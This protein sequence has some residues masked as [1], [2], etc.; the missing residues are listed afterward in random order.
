MPITGSGQIALIA[1][2]EAEFAQDGDTDISL[3]T[4]R[5]DAGLSGE[6]QMSDFYSQSDA[7][8]PSVSTSTSSSLTTS[9]MQANGNVSS[10]GGGTISSRGFYFGTSSNYASNTKY[11]VS[12]TTGGF[13]RNMTG[14]SSGTTYYS[15]AFAINSIGEVRGG[16]SGSSTSVL[17][18]MTTSSISVSAWS[19][20]GYFGGNLAINYQP[21]TFYSSG[22]PGGGITVS[23]YTYGAGVTSVTRYWQNGWSGQGSSNSISSGQVLSGKQLRI[24]L[25]QTPYTRPARNVGH[26]CSFS[27]SGYASG[28]LTTHNAFI[29]T[30]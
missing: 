4:A 13:N 28:S 27:S 5:D 12:G 11:T 26:G 21:C 15:T 1:D 14:L 24:H 18:I 20:T 9:S 16:T 29:N 19:G 30:N 3:F 23:G 2:I 7:V 8:A 17:N 22:A 6:I 10:D 25:Y